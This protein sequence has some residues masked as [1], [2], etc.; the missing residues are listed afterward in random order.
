M[1]LVLEVELHAA[2]AQSAANVD[3]WI[4]RFII[5][6]LLQKELVVIGAASGAAGNRSDRDSHGDCQGSPLP[7][8]PGDPKEPGKRRSTIRDW[9]GQ[10]QAMLRRAARLCHSARANEAT[11][12][13]GSSAVRCAP[14]DALRR[15]SVRESP[16]ESAGSCPPAVQLH[17]SNRVAA[18][19][20]PCCLCADASRCGSA[21]AQDPQAKSG[22]YP[23]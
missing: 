9:L 11:Q 18:H 12:P 7:A 23:R 17:A 10:K 1:P 20:R 15:H 22:P 2:K 5:S 8:V 13:V 19:C 3:N 4:R 21:Q 6:S 14:G 16:G